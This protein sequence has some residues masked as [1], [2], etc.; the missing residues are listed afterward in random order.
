[1]YRFSMTPKLPSL[2]FILVGS[3]DWLTTVIGIFYFGAIEAN[4]VMSSIAMTNLP[5]FTAIKFATTLVVGLMFYQAEKNL[6]T[7]QNKESKSFR[8]TKAG[9]RITYIAAIGF[10]SMVVLN[11][12][13]VVFNAV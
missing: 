1:M 5:L 6:R 3:M 10:L 7:T 13:I 12:I 8:L 4:P 11:N 9:L 2:A